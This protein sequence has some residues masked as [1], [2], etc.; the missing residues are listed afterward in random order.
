MVGPLTLKF[1]FG[2]KISRDTYNKFGHQV[3]S[4]LAHIS[5]DIIA[6]NVEI[7]TKFYSDI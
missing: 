2:V 3:T 4:N 5:D 6:N 7:L 1:R